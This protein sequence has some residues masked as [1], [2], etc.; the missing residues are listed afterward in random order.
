MLDLVPYTMSS[1]VEMSVET[2]STQPT[3]GNSGTVAAVEESRQPFRIGQLVRVQP[4]TDP[5]YNREGGV[6]H[7]TCITETTDGPTTVNVRYVI[8]GKRDKNIDIAEVEEHGERTRLRDRSVLL[9]RC[10]NCGSLRT[11]CG[12][13]DVNVGWKKRTTAKTGSVRFNVLP[14]S[15]SSSDEET[16]DFEKMMR[17]KRRRDR[18]Y[19]RFKAKA[20]RFLQ[21]DSTLLDIFGGEHSNSKA[22]EKED[23]GSA[24]SDG[25]SDDDITLQ[26]LFRASQPSTA[27]QRQ[28]TRSP[29]ILSTPRQRATRRR[30]Q[31]RRRLRHRRNSDSSSHASD[32]GN[33]APSEKQSAG[34]VSSPGTVDSSGSSRSE[35]RSALHSQSE[36]R[37]PLFD[38]AG[39]A[40][41][42]SGDGSGDTEHPRD[43]EDDFIQPEGDGH[44]LPA[45][46]L[47]PT[48]HLSFAELGPFLDKRV[49]DLKKDEIPK[50][51]EDVLA[52]EKEWKDATTNDR[53]YELVEKRYVPR[54]VRRS[55]VW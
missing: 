3:N 45:D 52:I 49:Q 53:K 30:C 43:F 51:R 55:C 2:T 23:K 4:R 42:S 24:E 13:C 21:E 40:E 12:S 9:G 28:L 10:R 32:N 31:K 25:S 47:D 29:W 22:T 48:D 33:D 8:G 41:F 1:P 50:A 27:P 34:Y 20:N 37:S 7:I 17:D 38:D 11:D 18:L 6:A 26:Q 16:S 15:S 36:V 35:R 14:S 19:H 46:T 54:L 39:V 44:V 5:G